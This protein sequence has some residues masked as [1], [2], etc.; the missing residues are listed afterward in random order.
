[1]GCLLEG[2]GDHCSPAKWHWIGSITS[3]GE[4]H[5]CIV[6]VEAGHRTRSGS[7]HRAPSGD[8]CRVWSRNRYQAH[9]QDRPGA[10][11]RNC[12]QVDPQD[13][14]ALSQDHIWEPTNRRVSF[15]MPEDGDSLM[16]RRDPTNELPIKDLELW[17]EYQVDQL[18]T[19]TWW[20]ELKAIPD[21]ADLHKFAWKI[22]ASFHVPEIQSQASP[23]QGYSAL[24]APRGLNRG[25]F[26]PE[27]LEYQDV[28]QRLILLMKA[29]CRCL[30]HWAE[31]SYLLVSWD[32][33]PLVESVRELCQAMSEFV[34]ITKQDI[35]EGLEMERPIDSCWLPPVTLFSWVLGPQTEGWEKTPVAIGIPWQDGMLRIWGRACPFLHVTLTRLPICLPGAPT[36]LTFSPTR[37]LA[38]GQPSILPWGF[39][40]TMTHTRMPEPT[41][42]DGKTST[43]IVSCWEN[44]TE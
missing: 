23:N 27:R 2:C 38:V 25:A 24:P 11:T 5:G 41:Q 36:M 3:W 22:W 39:I 1:M 32:A 34:T 37:A 43:D 6:R 20:G 31:K 9:S 8:W 42:S 17:L 4:G 13:E 18:G 35:L 10:Q 12:H 14:Q 28:W 40:D 30:Q 15:R 19:P 21:V 7:R 16:E 26:L 44:D 33:H 29:Y